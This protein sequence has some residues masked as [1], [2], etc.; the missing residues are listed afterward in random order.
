MFDRNCF[1]DAV[2]V[3]LVGRLANFLFK[4]LE[5]LLLFM[6]FMLFSMFLL[7][8]EVLLLVILTSD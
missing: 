1:I 7:P 8:D 5:M 4:V 3:V 2:V 6:L